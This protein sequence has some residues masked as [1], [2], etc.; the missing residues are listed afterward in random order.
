[1]FFFITSTATASV[2]LF[3]S[4]LA[5]L[6]HIKILYKGASSKMKNAKAAP[7][8][9]KKVLVCMSSRNPHGAN[10]IHVTRFYANR[11]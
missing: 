1:M 8:K 11:T 9:Q 2:F 4:R 3:L 6:D 5:P 10:K 7:I